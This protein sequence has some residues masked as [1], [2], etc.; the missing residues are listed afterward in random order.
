VMTASLAS[1]EGDAAAYGRPGSRSLLGGLV[2]VLLTQRGRAAVS[3][4]VQDAGLGA[5]GVASKVGLL[6]V[7]PLRESPVP[8]P[9]PLG[10]GFV[11]VFGAEGE[12]EIRQVF[13]LEPDASS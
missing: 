5:E 4:G 11:C 2:V 1:R 10:L 6:G 7:A 9:Q 8:H 3:A 13:E 12:I